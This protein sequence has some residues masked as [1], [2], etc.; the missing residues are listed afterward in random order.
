MPYNT[1]RPHASNY[2]SLAIAHAYS[3]SYANTTTQQWTAI[4]FT[5]WAVAT[6]ISIWK[7]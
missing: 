1:K 7:A 3:P 5:L 6:L 4:T 2:K